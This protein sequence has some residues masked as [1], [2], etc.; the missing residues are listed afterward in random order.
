MTN[1]ELV[2]KIRRILEDPESASP[3]EQR[4]AARLYATRVRRV[5][6]GFRRALGRLNNGELADADW[7][8]TDGSLL[9]DY[10]ALTLPGAEDWQVV[11]RTFDYEVALATVSPRSSRNTPRSATSSRNGDAKRWK[12]RRPVPS[13]KRFTT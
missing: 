6:E 7:I 9:E 10:A 13:L 12:T 8:L 5:Q 3:D 4:E 1:A 11:C 2:E